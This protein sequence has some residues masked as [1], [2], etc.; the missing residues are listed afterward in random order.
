[1]RDAE[2]RRALSG[3][4]RER[5]R[6]TETHEFSGRTAEAIAGYGSLLGETDDPAP[7]AEVRLALSRTRARGGRTAEAN[8]YY[9]VR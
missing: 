1:V 2:P 3:T 8:A 4:F 6:A 5:L 7:A 9:R